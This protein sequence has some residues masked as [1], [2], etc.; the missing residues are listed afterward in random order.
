MKT[1]ELRKK[2]LDY[3]SKKDSK[4]FVSASLVPAD[5]PTLL[6]TSAGMN[7][8]KDYFLGKNKSAS[9]ATSCQKCLRTGDLERVGKTKYHHTFFEMLGNFSF[10]DYFKKEAIEWAWEFVTKECGLDPKDIWVTVYTDDDESA[11]IWEKEVGV[12]RDKIVRYGSDDNFWPQNALENGIPGPCGPCSEIYFDYGVD[13]GCGGDDCGPACSCGRFVEVWNLVFTQYNCTGVNQKEPLPMKNIDT[14]MGLERMAGV[15]QGKTNNYD[16]DI[17]RP[18]VDEVARVLKT[19]ETLYLRAVTDHVRALTFCINDGIY[20]SNEDRGYVVRKILRR[21][22]WFGFVCG[23]KE[24]YL[25]KLVELVVELMKDQYPELVLKKATIEKVILSEEE[26]FLTTL[27]KGKEMLFSYIDGAKKENRTSLTG[28]EVFKLYDTFGFP[29]ELTANIAEEKGVQIDVEGFSTRL[30]QQKELSRR[31]SKFEESVFV[32][33]ELEFDAKTE[34]VGYENVQTRS[35]VKNIVSDNSFVDSFDGDIEILLVLDKT[36]F[37]ATKGGQV[38]DLGIISNDSFEFVVN[39]V[40]EMDGTFVHRG[41]LKNGSIKIGDLVVAD[42]DIER[43]MAIK[44]AHT[45][46]HLLQAALRDVLGEHVQQQGSFVDEDY[47]RFDFNHFKSLSISEINDIEENVNSKILA[48]YVVN[49]EEMDIEQAKSK[50]ALAFFED[51]YEDTVRVVSIGDISVEFCGGT[52]LDAT[53]E[54]GLL[55]IITESSVASGIRRIEA[56][57]GKKATS[58]LK[59][60]RQHEQSLCKKLKVQPDNLL[61]AVADLMTIKKMYAKKL[62]NM[63]LEKFEKVDSAE[64]IDKNSTEF[65]GVNTIVFSLTEQDS[66]FL[67]KAIDIV[68]KRVNENAVLVGISNEKTKLT[69]N[70]SRT[71]DLKTKGIS[72]GELANSIAQKFGASGGGK[73]NF[74]FCGMKQD[75]KAD[76]NQLKKTIVEVLKESL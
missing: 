25:Y 38:T 70:V 51:K 74:G 71:D 12:A 36:P 46:T 76:V 44:R 26:R 23:K 61:S 14:G 15:L 32:K 4:Y 65:N 27:D 48:N 8:F 24:P 54:A 62:E 30:E 20:P 68:R 29:F 50:G 67:R 10:G 41:R 6:F 7:Q 16:I 5:D 9:R 35:I 11:L 59:S 63:L 52:H 66:G 3:F 40:E 22:L 17:L 53:A 13:V 47:L 33:G 56:Y 58:L 1:A 18:I 69:I 43:R 42:V 2:Y 64:I 45:A 34:F 21:A 60:S 49:K 73:D 37:Y 31:S 19:D 55:V 72:C 57:T 28:E 75:D 39:A